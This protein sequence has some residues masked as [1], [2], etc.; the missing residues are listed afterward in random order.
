[1]DGQNAP[2]V[3]RQEIERRI[4]EIKAHMPDTYR[5]IQAKASEVGQQ[6]YAWV[7]RA[8]AGQPDLFYAIERGRVT[9]T[10]FRQSDITADVA[11]VMVQFNCRS[12]VMWCAPVA[13]GGANG[14]G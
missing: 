14:A 6:A 7:R 8:L 5:S 3:D 13:Q 10:P 2:Q 11:Q 9:G 4:A 12:V 1:M